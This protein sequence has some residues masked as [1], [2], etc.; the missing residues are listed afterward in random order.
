ML[1]RLRRKKNVKFN[2]L[3]LV[4]ICAYQYNFNDLKILYEYFEKMK[5]KDEKKVIEKIISK[6]FMANCL[7]CLIEY[8]MNEDFHLLTIKD[9]HV[10]EILK[11]KDF[12]HIV[13]IDCYSRYDLKE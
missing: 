13:C 11:Q 8:R 7:S 3:E 10:T 5:M 6:T 9:K 4:C 12:K 2:N 1:L